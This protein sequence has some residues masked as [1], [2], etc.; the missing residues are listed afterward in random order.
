MKLETQSIQN[1]K[2]MFVEVSHFFR[3][4]YQFL[5]EINRQGIPS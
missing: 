2:N 3:F 4:N 1:F 5:F